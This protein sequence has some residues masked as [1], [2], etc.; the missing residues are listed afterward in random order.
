MK[1]DSNPMTGI[2]KRRGKFGPPNIQREHY[3]TIETEVGVMHISATMR[4]K[5]RDQRNIFSFST[6][7]KKR[8]PNNTAI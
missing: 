5:E 1:V 2:I 3:M 8:G 7:L 4:S 6:F